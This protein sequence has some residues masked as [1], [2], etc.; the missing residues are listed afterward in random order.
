MELETSI[1]TAIDQLSRLEDLYWQLRSILETEMAE[2][3]K[4][5]DDKREDAKREDNKKLDED[6]VDKREYNDHDL[7][8]IY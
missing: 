7:D 6:N 1:K 8:S 2:R 3:N 4:H 5:A